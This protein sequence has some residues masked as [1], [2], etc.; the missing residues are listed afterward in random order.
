MDKE[1][2]ANL[3]GNAAQNFALL[4]MRFLAS[5]DSTSHFCHL[6]QCHGVFDKIIKCV[7]HVK[8]R[9]EAKLEAFVKMQMIRNQWRS[10]HKNLGGPRGMILG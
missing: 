6:F 7:I 9:R 4:C 2:E 10:Q 3:S 5:T 1:K 8:N